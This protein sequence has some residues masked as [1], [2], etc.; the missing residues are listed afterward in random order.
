M[1]SNKAKIEAAK[2]D[3]ELK[4][5]ILR[6]N[7]ILWMDEWNLA[8]NPFLAV[9]NY[10]SEEQRKKRKPIVDAWLQAVASYDAVKPKQR[11]SA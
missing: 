10:L 4:T 5:R 2:N 1:T 8:P 6:A 9:S 11:A 7:E 3:A